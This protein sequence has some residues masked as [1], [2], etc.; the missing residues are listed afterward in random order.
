MVAGGRDGVPV[1]GDGGEVAA[2]RHEVLEL[3]L[4]EDAAQVPGHLVPRGQLV[5]DI[6]L[7]GARDVGELGRVQDDQVDA[8]AHEKAVRVDGQGP[9]ARHHLPLVAG[10]VQLEQVGLALAELVVD[11]VAERAHEDLEV[12]LVQVDPRTRAQPLSS[13]TRLAR[14]ARSWTEVAGFQGSSAPIP[15]GVSFWCASSSDMSGSFVTS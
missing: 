13:A 11:A 3:V 9:A 4:V 1:L 12:G 2:L 5:A 8:L 7:A 10:G 14:R 6:G 15:D